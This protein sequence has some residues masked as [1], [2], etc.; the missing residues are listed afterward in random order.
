[1]NPD[2]LNSQS[3]PTPFAF[4][5]YTEFFITIICTVHSVFVIAYVLDACVASH[6][7]ISP[8]L[9][10]EGP[11]AREGHSAALVGKRL[12]VFGGCGKSANNNEEVY[13]ND[14]Y[15][16]NIGKPSICDRWF[17]ICIYFGLGVTFTYVLVTDQYR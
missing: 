12:F 1:M 6:T 17:E 16:L 2:I 11:E 9:R 10:G 5:A 14:L 15:I 7:W 13:Y 4:R 8:T 3:L